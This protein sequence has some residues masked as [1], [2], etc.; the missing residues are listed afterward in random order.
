[1][2]LKQ[3]VRKLVPEPLISVYHW[4]L[5]KLAAIVFGFPSRQLI[6]IGITGT[7]GKSTTVQFLGQML[8]AAGKR[9]GWASTVSFKIA[10]KEWVNDKKMTMLGRFQTQKLLRQM[11][12][13]GCEYAIVEVSSQGIVQHRHVGINFDIATLTNLWPEHIEAHGGFENYKKAKGKFFEYVAKSPLKKLAGKVIH[14]SFVV[15][16]DNEHAP[17]FLGLV[18][19]GNQVVEF[20]ID[21][22]EVK[23]S[24]DG[25]EFNWEDLPAFIEPIG[26]PNV[27]NAVCAASIT[28][29]LDFSLSETV[30]VMEKI[31]SVSGRLESIDEGQDFFVIVDYAFEPKA[32]TSLYETIRLL[33]HQKIIHVLGSTGGGRDIARRPVLGKIAGEKADVVI[34]TNEDPYD[35]D[36]QNIIDQVTA[37]ALEVGKQENENLFRILDRQAAIEKAVALAKTGDLIL[38]TGKGSEPVMAVANG[39]TI[40]WDDR[41]AVRTALKKIF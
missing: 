33:P 20:R 11:V 2:T 10:D 21:T 36:P 12:T 18:G 26:L 38:I 37:G 41:R 13:A 32:L 39:K 16:V 15:N 9:V 29:A 31:K 30:T 24:A 35:D 6:V 8:E 1:M 14:K 27:Y 25:S 28:K 34:V 23:L 17:Y 4:F 3:T 40:P 19:E 7:S 22:E 5:A